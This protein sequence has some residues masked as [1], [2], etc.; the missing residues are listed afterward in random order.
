M[1]GWALEYSPGNILSASFLVH[2]AQR[3]L[4]IQ[5]LVGMEDIIILGEFLKITAVVQ[6]NL[7]IIGT[8]ILG[9]SR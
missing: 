9:I 8:L 1:G 4:A 3:L 2:R 5:E 7:G 6:I